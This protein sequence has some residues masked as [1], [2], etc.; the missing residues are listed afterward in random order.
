MHLI[1]HI[2]LKHARQG[3]EME[4][5]IECKYCG[6]KFD[7]K[8][9]FMSHRKSEHPG[10]VAFCRNN[11]LEKCYF[12]AEACWW[13]HSKEKSN[14]SKKIT[15]YICAKAFN[16]RAEMMVHRKMNHL[17]VVRQ[18]ELFMKNNCTFNDSSCWFL[19]GTENNE[20]EENEVIVEKEFNTSGFWKTPLDP[21]PPFK[22]PSKKQKVD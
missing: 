19:H 5:I 22:N 1:K 11:A 10:T 3:A 7:E 9:K 20:K 4:S 8:R 14:D 21:K 15:C 12:S 6:E 16:S 17:K 2:N 13:S 18:C